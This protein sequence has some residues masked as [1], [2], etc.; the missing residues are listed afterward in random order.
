MLTLLL[1]GARSGKSRLGLQLAERSAA[2]VTFVATGE[3]R[4]EEMAARIAAHRAERPQHWATVEAPLHLEQ[5]LRQVPEGTTVVID[6]LT[7]WVANLMEAGRSD[8]EVLGPAGAVAAHAATR[9]GTAIVI[10]NEVG[11]G[12][13]PADAASR[14]YRDLLGRVNTSFAEGAARA[15]LVVAGRALELSPLVTR[16]ATL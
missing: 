9:A 7:L 6:C 13:V 1:G 14:R 2:P 5:A 10:S 11:W 15:L 4:D 3:G 16:T 8:D 12:I